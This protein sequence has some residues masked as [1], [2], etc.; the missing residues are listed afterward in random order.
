MSIACAAFCDQS[1]GGEKDIELVHGV[2]YGETRGESEGAS[3]LVLHVAKGEREPFVI[4]GPIAGADIEV[5]FTDLVREGGARIG[6]ERFTPL[7]VEFSTAKIPLSPALARKRKF[8]RRRTPLKEI[9]VPDRLVPLGKA[10]HP[11]EAVWVTLSVPREAESGEY[12]G[13]LSVAAGGTIRSGKLTVMVWDF[14]LPKSP[15]LRVVAGPPRHSRSVRTQWEKI[16]EEFASHRVSLRGVENPSIRFEG[17]TPRIEWKEFDRKIVK[18]VSLGM[19]GFHFPFI[20]VVGGHGRRYSRQFGPFGRGKISEEFKHKFTATVREVHAH[21]K[22][23]GW[24]DRFIPIFTDEPYENQY[25]ETRA[26]ANLI[27]SA[28]PDLQPASFGPLPDPRLAGHIRH[29]ITPIYRLDPAWT[30]GLGRSLGQEKIASIRSVLN[31][32]LKAGDRWSVYNPLEEYALA[33]SPVEQR[34]LYWWCW[35]KKVDGLFQWTVMDGRRRPE[36]NR[37]FD[38]CWVYVDD[39]GMIIP[40]IRWEMTREGIEDADYLALYEKRHGRAR[41]E[42]L[43]REIVR[44]L[45]DRTLDPEKLIELRLK[46]GKAIS[47]P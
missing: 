45:T 1:P 14:T 33:A 23:R 29:W 9:R 15:F 12:E 30:D 21:L 43:C 46:I 44:T 35:L 42:S 4:L 36:F 8:N 39:A 2:M 20:Y 3:S 31:G 47:G 17:N 37:D 6:K 18:L 28:A 13:T 25:E 34:T 27:Q 19:R 38:S 41:A 22:K 32:R 11:I 26:L 16:A 40:T 5:R 7:A 10:S 24:L